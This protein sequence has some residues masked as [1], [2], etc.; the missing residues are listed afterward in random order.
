LAPEQDEVI[1]TKFE[2]VQGI[3]P[4]SFYPQLDHYINWAEG[5]GKV[6]PVLN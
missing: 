2:H 4:R 1:M 5:K 6:V 3:E